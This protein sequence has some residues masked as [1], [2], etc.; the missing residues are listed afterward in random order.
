MTYSTKQLRQI[1]FRGVLSTAM[2]YDDI[3][4]IDHLRYVNDNLVMGASDI[5]G[6]EENGV[7]YFFLQRQKN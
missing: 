2:L 1:M 3:P 6:S 5:K 4:T 7:F